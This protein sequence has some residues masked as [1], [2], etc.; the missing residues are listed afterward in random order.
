MFLGS[1]GFLSWLSS[2]VFFSNC[3]VNEYVYLLEIALDILGKLSHDSWNVCECL[4]P[5]EMHIE[6]T[7]MIICL[8]NTNLMDTFT[9]SKR[10]VLY[11]VNLICVHQQKLSLI[12][13][14]R[15]KYLTCLKHQ[16]NKTVVLMFCGSYF[17]Y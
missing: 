4:T 5:N 8:I 7:S 10:T 6:L 15:T 17:Q 2:Y 16:I 3:G 9:W 14:L 13:N 1:F 11:I 12:E